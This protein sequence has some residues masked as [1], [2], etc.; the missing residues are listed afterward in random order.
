MSVATPVSSAVTAIS[1]S[2][3]ETASRPIDAAVATRPPTIVVRRP[4]RSASQPPRGWE[5][6][7]PTPKQVTIAPAVVNDSERPR[8]R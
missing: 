6:N 4:N 5:M 2:E 8:T 7:D 1:G 3:R